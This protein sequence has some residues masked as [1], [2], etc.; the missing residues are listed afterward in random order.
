MDSV[1]VSSLKAYLILKEH[2]PAVKRMLKVS[3]VLF[4][5]NLINRATKQDEEMIIKFLAYRDVCLY[6]LNLYNIEN[7]P[8]IM[9][10]FILWSYR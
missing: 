10:E 6:Y 8:N 9:N 7:D 4:D 5:S 3:E 1:F 2:E